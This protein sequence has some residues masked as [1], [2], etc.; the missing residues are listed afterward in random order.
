MSLELRISPDS[1]EHA[2]LQHADL[3]REVRLADKSKPADEPEHALVCALCRHPI[4]SERQRIEVNGSHQHHCVNPAGLLFHIGCFGDAPGCA[5]WGEPTTEFTWF[6]GFA[7]CYALCRSC[8]A[9]LGWRFGGTADDVFFGLV[10]N[11][12]ASEQAKKI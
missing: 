11:R 2:A 7:W 6:P 12:L 8:R 4:T 10:L 3:E 5:A 9:H 1:V